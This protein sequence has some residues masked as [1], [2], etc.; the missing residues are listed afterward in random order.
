[1]FILV[2]VVIFG[3]KKGVFTTYAS[4]WNF[5]YFNLNQL[6]INFFNKKYSNLNFFNFYTL[7][8]FTHAYL[9][10]LNLDFLIVRV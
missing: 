5:K 9:N 8:R 1:M 10:S 6:I 7:Y 4:F 3:P 2:F